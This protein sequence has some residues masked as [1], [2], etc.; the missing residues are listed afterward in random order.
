MNWKAFLQTLI[1]AAFN[2]AIG[3]GVSKLTHSPMAGV[4]TMT[5]GT[6]IAHG[7]ASPFRV[8]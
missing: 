8:K 4:G 2:A 3:V 6:A 7:M 5:A 1:T